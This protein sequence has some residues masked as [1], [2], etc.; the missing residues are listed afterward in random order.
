MKKKKTEYPNCKEEYQKK[1]SEYLLKIKE[2]DDS[3]EENINDKIKSHLYKMVELIDSMEIKS[4]GIEALTV[5]LNKLKELLIDKK[6][7][8]ALVFYFNDYSGDLS[9]STFGAIDTNYMMPTEL[10]LENRLNN[11]IIG[12][13][14]PIQISNYSE[15][16]EDALYYNEIDECDLEY[17]NDYLRELATL[18]AY[19]IF[20]EIFLTIDLKTIFSNTQIIYPFYSYIQEH[21]GGYSNLLRV[22]KNDHNI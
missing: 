17:E 19:A 5:S 9:L 13:L 18:K 6:P 8:Q 11:Q 10:S 15:I 2:F 21:D 22:L 16:Y 1:K 4:K 12:D 20:E 7:I 3:E 14:G